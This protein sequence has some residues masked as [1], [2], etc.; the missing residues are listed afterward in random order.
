MAEIE[1]EEQVK[2]EKLIVGKVRTL[3]EGDRIISFSDA[4]FA[5]AATLLVLKLDLPAIPPDLMQKQFVSELIKLIPSYTANFVSFLIIAYYWWLHHK[6]FILI[7]KYDGVIVWMNIMVLIFVSFLPFPI[8]LFGEYPRIVGVDVFYTLSLSIVGIMLLA[9][10]V[11]ASYKHRLIGRSMSKRI[12]LYHT[13]YMAAAPFV[14]LVSIPLIY[15]DQT[16]AK[17]SWL[18]V[19]VIISILDSIFR[20]DI[21]KYI[22]YNPEPE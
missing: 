16:V 6:L 10:W 3:I 14:F 21:E 9:L 18:M 15:Y 2:E 1:R 19:I 22:A 20:E 5:F 8:D 7:K 11:Y 13:L 12:V 17:V 4:V